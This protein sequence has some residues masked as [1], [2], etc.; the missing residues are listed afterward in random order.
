MFPYVDIAIRRYHS[1][2]RKYETVTLYRYDYEYYFL[3]NL[4]DVLLLCTLINKRRDFV[5]G[6]PRPTRAAWRLH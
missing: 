6:L 4:F 5:V 3:D 2:G 1:N